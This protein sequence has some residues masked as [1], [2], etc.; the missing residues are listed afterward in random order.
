MT[1]PREQAQTRG[2]DTAA[3]EP[4]VYV[5]GLWRRL[6]AALLDAL[7][8][9]PVLWLLG[10]L[11]FFVAGYR[12]PLG[13]VLSVESLLELLL[14]SGGALHGFLGVGLVILLLYGFLFLTTTGAT[15]GLRVLGLRVISVYGQR[16]EWWRMLL[17]CG[18]VVLSVLLLGLGF[19][20]MGF[21]R[22]KRGLHDWMAG[23]YVIRSKVERKVLREA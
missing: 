19:L 22:E 12:A 18:G 14:D 21:D 16:P 17:R 3:G 7:L 11:V 8:L 5:A 20:W 2:P 9:A 1:E 4:A 23:T 10:F 6:C 15:P 13:P